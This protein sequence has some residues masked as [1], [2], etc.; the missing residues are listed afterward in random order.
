MKMLKTSH[1]YPVKHKIKTKF[2]IKK[3]GNPQALY[4]SLHIPA[5]GWQSFS[6][7]LCHCHLATHNRIWYSQMKGMSMTT[8]LTL[9]R[10]QRECRYSCCRSSSMLGLSLGSLVRHLY[11][12]K[13]ASVKSKLVFDNQ[14]LLWNW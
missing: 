10:T 12:I 9:H 1:N 4:P 5:E 13:I 7:K 6:F 14:P 3:T 11:R 2:S 8:W